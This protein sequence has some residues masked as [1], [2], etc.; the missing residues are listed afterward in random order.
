MNKNSLIAWYQE[1]LPT[2]KTRKEQILH[3]VKAYSQDEGITMLA[4]AK[5]LDVPV[6]TISGRFG[7]LE[8]EGKLKTEGTTKYKGSKAPHSLYKI[9][10]L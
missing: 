9:V 3:I 5:V 10:K 7:E 1:V 4:V 8:R 2:L 6:H